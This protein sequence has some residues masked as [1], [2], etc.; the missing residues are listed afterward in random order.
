MTS[1]VSTILKTFFFAT[2]ILCGLL[3]TTFFTPHASAQFLA[4]VSNGPQ[5]ELTPKYPR[6][7]E[8]VAIRFA[9]YGYSS[10]GT[11]SW[12]LDGAR[13]GDGDSQTTI[14]LTAPALGT[15][16]RVEARLQTAS[17]VRTARTTIVPMEVDIIVEAPTTAPYFYEGRRVPTVGTQARVVAIPHIYDE[18]GVRIPASQLSYSWTLNNR[19]TK[20]AQGDT[21][22]ETQLSPIGDSL[23]TLSIDAVGSTAHFETHFAIPLAA[24]SLSFHH[25]DPKRGMER[26]AVRDHYLRTQGEVTVRAEPYFVA[27]DI[28]RNAQHGWTVNQQVTGNGNSDP[29]LITLRAGEGGGMS[30]VGFSVRNLSALSQFA[31]GLF[32]LVFE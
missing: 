23:V 12:Y 29:Q 6:P 17:G 7:G 4:G 30:E 25:I 2:I 19:L 22:L 1:R 5:L 16:R 26:S 14:S 3:T 28:Y 15:P 13:L 21:V 20:A 18:R 9:D 32:Q 24:P 8:Q 27:R 11:L 31:E 10:G